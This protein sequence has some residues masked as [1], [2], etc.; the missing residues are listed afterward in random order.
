MM[1]GK[2]AAITGGSGTLGR[3]FIKGLVEQGVQVFSLDRTKETSLKM[4]EEFKAMGHEVH[5]IQCDVLDEESVNN[6]VKQVLDAAGKID[7]L[8]NS[9]GGNMSGAT[10]M[11]EQTVSDISVEQFRKVNDLNLL[12]TV[13]PTIAFTKPMVEQ[14]TGCIIN[15]S[16]MAA[17]APLTRVVGYSASK[18]AINSFTQW[19]SVELA[20]KHGIR[21]AGATGIVT[22]LH[23]IANGEVWPVAEIQ[24]R[25]QE[26]ESAGLVWSVVESIPVHE[27]IK[28]ASGNFL[29][30]IEN[31]KQ[32]IRNLAECDIRIVTYNFMPV[33][34]WSRTELEHKMPDG[35]TAL[36]FEKAA[37]AAFDLFILNRPNAD[38]YYTQKDIE[39]AKSYYAKMSAEEKDKLTK[40]IIAG[41]PGGTTEG[42]LDL[43]KFQ[44]ILD[45]YKSV[46]EDKLRAN[47][48]FFLQQIA[49]VADECN[50]K[51]AIHPE[52]R[53]RS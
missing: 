47:L 41:L 18:A 32:S 36:F 9:A 20:N 7:I 24:K 23:H 3:A 17:F 13:I 14:G 49:P 28:R 45:T 46:D 31:Y 1:K 50:V 12:G 25:K 35:S 40:N 53:S 34:D 27:D 11:P 43:D 37:F 16:S 30:H 21:Q 2:V 5:S 38:Q 22:A 26:I 44:K 8:V 29:A 48:V 15:I 52:T 4:V 39:K 51:L 10:V 42:V 33:L 19:M 6:A